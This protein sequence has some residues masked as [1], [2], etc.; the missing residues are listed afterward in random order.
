MASAGRC[1]PRLP[2]DPVILQATLG[3]SRQAPVL[4]F[5]RRQLAGLVS[6]STE[7]QSILKK[8]QISPPE[9]FFLTRVN[10]LDRISEFQSIF[11]RASLR[12]AYGRVC[13]FVLRSVETAVRL[14]DLRNP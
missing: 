6:G 7:F 1:T 2:A 9:I 13:R 3:V 11:H 5:D 8:L 4:A 12:L 14:M 10:L